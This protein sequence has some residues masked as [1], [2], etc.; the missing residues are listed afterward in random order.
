[1]CG[2]TKLNN[3][4]D[5]AGKSLSE[6]NPVLGTRLFVWC[7]RDRSGVGG[8]GVVMRERSG[9]GGRGVGRVAFTSRKDCVRV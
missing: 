2:T 9:V 4:W 7:R 1:M 5:N 6:I 3:A 8:R